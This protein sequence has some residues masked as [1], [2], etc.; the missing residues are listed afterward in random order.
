[1]SLEVFNTSY[2]PVYSQSLKQVC[3]QYQ[4]HFSDKITEAQRHLATCLNSP[5]CLVTEY[6]SE[7]KSYFSTSLFFLTHYVIHSGDA[8]FCQ[9]VILK[10]LSRLTLTYLGK[11]FYGSMSL[12][13]PIGLL[14]N[15]LT[16]QVVLVNN[17]A[18]RKTLKTVERIAEG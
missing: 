14:L 4:F 10:M 15:I 5:S 11:I 9:L 18:F 2:F 13:V 1:M 17:F 12:S 8:L 16:F 6:E 7:S 3:S